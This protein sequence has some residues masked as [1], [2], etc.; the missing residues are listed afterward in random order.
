MTPLVFSLATL[1]AVAAAPRGCLVFE[2]RRGRLV[3]SP[4]ATAAALV[5]KR[6]GKDWICHK[7][8]IPLAEAWFADGY[9]YA[10]RARGDSGRLV[11]AFAKHPTTLVYDVRPEADWIVFSIRSVSGPRPR[12]L[13]MLRLAVDQTTNVGRYLGAAWDEHLFLGLMAANHQASASARREARGRGAKRFVYACLRGTTQ[14][15][16]G[17]RLEGAAIALLVLPAAGVRERLERA[18]VAFGLLTNTR[19]GVPAKYLPEVRRS[20]WFITLSEN[21]A[22]KMIDYCRKTGFRQVLLGFGSWCSSAGHYLFNKKRF[23]DG[24]EGLKRFVDKLH[25]A[26]ILVGMHTFASKVSKR[27]PY[28]TPVPDRRFWTDMTAVLA[29]DVD[30]AQTTIRMKDRLDQWPGCP[31]CKRKSWEGGVWKHRE[32]ILDDEIIQYERI[33]PPGVWNTFQGCRRGAWGTLP[34]AHRAGTTGRHYA[35][36][37]CINGYIID[38]ETSLIDET[39]SR[40]ADI[41]NYCGFDM[42]Y[43][44][45]GEDVDRRRY[46]YYVTKFQ[47]TA[48]RKFVKRPII[49]MGTCLTH[50]LWHSFARSGTVDVY[51]G[52][53]RGH[54]V[55]RGARWLGDFR[56][57]YPDG[58]V[59][60]WRT[61]KEHIDKSVRR[62]RRLRESMMPAELGWFGIWP[63]SKYSDGLQL[64]EIEYLMVKSLAYDCPISLETSFKSMD[65]HPLTPQILQ[66]VKTYEQLRIARAV[67]AAARERLQP[68]GRDFILVQRGGRREFVEVQEM[69]KVAGTHDVRAFVGAYHDGAVATIWHYARDGML[70][71]AVDPARLS[72]ATFLGE[73]I[74]LQKRAG[75]VTLRVDNWRTTLFFD[76]LSPAAARRAL[77]RGEFQPQPT[78]KLWIQAE[79]FRRRVGA[80]ARGSEVGVREPDAFGDVVVCTAHANFH[81]TEPYYCEYEVNIPHAG[82]WTIWGRMRFPSKRDDSFGLVPAGQ[83]PTLT[84]AQVFGNCGASAGRWHWS[85]RGGGL[86][87]E[88][89]GV[90]ITLKLPKGRFTFRVYARE[91]PGPAARNPRL[92]VICLS[93][94]PSYRPS[95]ADARAGLNAAGE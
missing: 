4:R 95:D 92:D 57:Q 23:P 25:A 82:F 33:G 9:D 16:P 69:P 21:E 2:N 85:G 30:A 70:T 22:D 40:L 50:R 83:K 48:M 35:V 20:Y 76:G 60:K 11:L 79:N 5:D 10:N 87:S 86:T 17:P 93:D 58:S 72:A 13:T 12:R 84:G 67:D 78:L 88:P 49:H 62:A 29:E 43:F 51:V 75:A 44:D 27:D 37:G 55:S 81:K 45:G 53:L 36:D 46:D 14:D 18:A 34:A 74:A 47:E 90:P 8:T 64:D 65:A 56:I 26:G 31:V 73:P 19:N 39:T 80:M 68:L 41:F 52:T 38:Q 3:V 1:F 7:R 54:I 63:K 66:I 24:K 71:L 32:V 61:V 28:V 91:A 94:E 77:A 42:V 59:R 15:A 89:P 6:T